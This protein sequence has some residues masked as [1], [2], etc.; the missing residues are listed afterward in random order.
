MEKKYLITQ[1]Q[2]DNINHYQRMFE[3]NAE[4]INNLCSSE[5]DDVVYGFKLGE[6]YTHLRTCFIEMMSLESEIKNQLVENEKKK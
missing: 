1:D 2:F 4:L 3:I 5:K 6:I